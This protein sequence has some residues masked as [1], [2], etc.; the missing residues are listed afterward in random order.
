VIH[1]AQK[2]KLLDSKMVLTNENCMMELDVKLAA[3][4][5]LMPDGRNLG[6]VIDIED[7]DGHHKPTSSFFRQRDCTPP[8]DGK[9]PPFLPSL[10]KLVQP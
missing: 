8:A 10:S 7:S 6:L 5:W 1:T 4:W 2:K 3:H 9:P